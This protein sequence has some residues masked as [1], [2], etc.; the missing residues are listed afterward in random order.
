MTSILIPFPYA[1]H[2]HQVMNANSL[3]SA[4]GADMILEKDLT[5]DTLAERIK[6]Y[7]QHTDELE[8][9]SSL[10]LKAGRPRATKVIVDQLIE[11]MNEN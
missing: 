9:M 8:R 2:D 7:M 10:A 6:R 5:G 11:L 4:G 1:T 3:L